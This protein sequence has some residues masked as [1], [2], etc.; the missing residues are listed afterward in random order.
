MSSLFDGSLGLDPI[1]SL[2]SR[3]PSL[4][5]S[6]PPTPTINNS[7]SASVSDK[8]RKLRVN[9]LKAV[10]KDVNAKLSGPKADLVSRL[11]TLLKDPLQA[12]KIYKKIHEVW[13]SRFEKNVPAQVPTVPSMSLTTP[14]PSIVSRSVPRPQDARHMSHQQL[15]AARSSGMRPPHSGRPINKG[16]LA[17]LQHITDLVLRAHKAMPK[18]P[19]HARILPVLSPLPL[20]RLS[21]GSDREGRIVRGCKMVFNSKHLEMLRYPRMHGADEFRVFLSCY[22]Y[23]IQKSSMIEEFPKDVEISLGRNSFKDQLRNR[24]RPLDIT[25]CVLAAS[26]PDQPSTEMILRFHQQRRSNRQDPLDMSIVTVFLATPVTPNKLLARLV[27]TAI[28]SA[29]CQFRVEAKLNEESQDSD[30]SVGKTFITLQCPLSQSRITTPC[31]GEDCSHLQCFD[32]LFFLQMNL[33]KPSWV[34]PICNRKA[35]F[36]SLRIDEL[37]AE[38]LKEAPKDVND[39]EFLPDGKWKFRSQAEAAEHQAQAPVPPSKRRKSQHAQQQQQPLPDFPILNNNDLLELNL[40]PFDLDL[41]D[42]FAPIDWSNF[43]GNSSASTTNTPTTQ[44]NG[45]TSQMQSG[46]PNE[47]IYID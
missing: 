16:A 47:P 42:P 45:L 6:P 26:Q 33:R 11:E 27:Q 14:R 3:R 2:Q 40:E 24:F 46:R 44:S 1:L 5:V 28:P 30:V 23:A 4:A 18:N 12:P 35:H 21:S 37:F 15:L 20:V 9:D 13:V 7:G 34:C 8:L 22:V 25:D 10:L 32:A 38:I 43:G 29:L 36:D 19:F 39:V 41:S 17:R 31:R